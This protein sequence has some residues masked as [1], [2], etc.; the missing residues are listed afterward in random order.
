MHRV[1]FDLMA[2][3]VLLLVLLGAASFDGCGHVAVDSNGEIVLQQWAK[4]AMHLLHAQ[5]NGCAHLKLDRWQTCSQ[6]HAKLAMLAHELDLI[7]TWLLSGWAEGD[8]LSNAHH[9]VKGLSGNCTVG[10]SY[11]HLCL[12]TADRRRTLN[13]TVH[14][15]QAVT[16]SRA[17]MYRLWIFQ[18]KRFC[19]GYAP[20]QVQ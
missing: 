6:G 20:T 3:K 15:L 14:D 5:L 18:H 7:F 10:C 11:M 9:L 17:Q 12:S 8:L 4:S 16:H 13:G 2:K 19:G 1:S